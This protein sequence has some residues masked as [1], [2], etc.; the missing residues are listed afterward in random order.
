MGDHGSGQAGQDF[1]QTPRTVHMPTATAPMLSPGTAQLT[2]DAVKSYDGIVARGGWPTVPQAG[3][4]KVG[5]R[6]AAVVEL[7]QRLAIDC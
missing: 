4:L 1:D 2:Q 5:V 6:D 7:R 3:E